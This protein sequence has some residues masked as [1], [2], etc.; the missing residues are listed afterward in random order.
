MLI[1]VIPQSKMGVY[2]GIFNFFIVIPQIV[3]GVFGG[4]IVSNIFG[5]M[6]IDY[7]FV[8]GV[9]MLIAAAVTMFLIKNDQ[10][11]TPKELEEEIQ[12]VHF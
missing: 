10:N 2:M 1:D 9:C 8:G 6:A 5:K 7:V 4:M 3:N 12:Q 11:E